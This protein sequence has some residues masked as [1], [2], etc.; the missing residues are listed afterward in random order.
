MIRSSQ[1]SLKFMNIG[2]KDLYLSFLTEY[3]RVG[4]LIIDNIWQ[5]G[6][7]DFNIK[8]DKLNLP[9]YID[10]NHFNIETSLSAR[11]LSS[12]V[13]QI[14][15]CLRSVTAPRRK[16]LFR[17]S[18]LHDAR[19]PNQKLRKE[20]KKVT[21]SKPNFSNVNPDL[22]SKCVDIQRGNHFDYFIRIK[23]VGKEFGH[24][25]IPIK[26]TEVSNKWNKKGNLLNGVRLQDGNIYL[27]FEVANSYKKRGKTVGADQGILDVITFSTGKTAGKVDNHNHTLQAIT[28][29]LARKRKGSKAFKKAQDHRKNFI[30]WS[31]NQISFKGVKQINLEKIYNIGYKSKRSRFLSHFCNTLIRDKIKRKADEQEVLVVEQDCAYRSQR[32]SRCGL[33]R[34]ANRKDKTY[35]CKACGFQCDAD[36]NAARNHAT[37]LP[38]IPYDFRSQKHNLGNGFYWKPAGLFS[39]DGMELRVPFSKI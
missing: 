32:C 22:S 12:L 8:L 1:H 17:I 35:I 6:Y 9:K 5:N 31:V 30:N 37:Q 19:K 13:T 7:K 18:K 11:A 29:K 23:S 38:D 2:K 21:F 10:Y 15:A 20:L 3:R 25:L 16:L 24:I 4:Q 28:K 36:L 27:N 39:F 33:V 14:S 26:A 34:K